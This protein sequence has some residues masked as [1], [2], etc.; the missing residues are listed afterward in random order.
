MLPLSATLATFGLLLCTLASADNTNY[1]IY[2]AK[3]YDNDGVNSITL[4]EG[5]KSILQWKTTW[6]TGGIYLLQEGNPSPLL[7]PNSGRR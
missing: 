2:P 3:N 7:L 4:V 1:F 6:D 5:T